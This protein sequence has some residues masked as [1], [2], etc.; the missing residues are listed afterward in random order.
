MLEQWFEQ[1]SGDFS[2]STVVETRGV[3]DRY[4]LPALG[5]VRL[6]KLRSSDL[7]LVREQ[8]GREPTTRFS[9]VARC[10]GG[11]PLVIRNHPLDAHGRPFPTL[12]EEEL[13]A[14]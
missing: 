1:A 8:L 4:L 12:I 7:V 13:D 9:V 11:H 2:P 10:P 14:C 6:D 3:I 5:K